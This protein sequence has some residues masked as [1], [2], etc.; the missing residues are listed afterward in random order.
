M[1][2]YNVSGQYTQLIDRQKQTLQE[3]KKRL[4]QRPR[5]RK[6]REDAYSKFMVALMF[7][8]DRTQKHMVHSSFIPP[9]YVPCITPLAELRRV[10][11]KD[12]QLETHHRGTCLLLRSITPPSRMTAIMAL[13]E[14]ENGDA[15]MLQLYQQEDEDIRAAA[16]IVNVGT[17]LLV[18]EPYFK[19]MGDGEYGLRVDHLS[20]FIHLSR[21]DARIPK[22]W[23]SQVIEI[24][25]SAKSL[26]INGNLAMK[27]GRY[28]DAITE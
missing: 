23:R 4:G 17:I 12:L 11:I 6:S 18:K 24:G 7:T 28:W 22:A 15:I 26:K 25:R 2:I 3:A 14:D 27:E 8:G 16:D 9:A 19:V 5:D 21:D 20:D 1:D 13:M 10:A